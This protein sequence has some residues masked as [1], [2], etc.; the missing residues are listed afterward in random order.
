[1][2]STIYRAYYDKYLFP[3]L[4]E[5]III[6]EKIGLPYKVLYYKLNIMEVPQKAGDYTPCFF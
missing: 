2:F 1:M 5:F 3:S 4:E 6:L